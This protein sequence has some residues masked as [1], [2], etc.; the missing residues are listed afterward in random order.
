[1]DLMYCLV[2]NDN[3]KAV[4]YRNCLILVL[5]ENTGKLR[6]TCIY[7]I[8]TRSEDVYIVYYHLT[9]SSIDLQ[10]EES[11]TFVKSSKPAQNSSIQLKKS[12]KVN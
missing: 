6:R 2:K 11:K 8:H 1:M 4:G 9:P 3:V 12:S 7:F 10:L 5:N